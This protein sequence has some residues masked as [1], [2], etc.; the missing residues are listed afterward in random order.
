MRCG[1]TNVQE[2]MFTMNFRKVGYV[3]FSS[4][5][6]ESGSLRYNQYI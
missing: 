4:A 1:L 6:E 2:Y 5:I 3:K